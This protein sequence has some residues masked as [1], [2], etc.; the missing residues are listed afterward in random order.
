MTGKLNGVGQQVAHDLLQ[1]SGVEVHQD[2]IF[3]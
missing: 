3:G 1:L 2:A